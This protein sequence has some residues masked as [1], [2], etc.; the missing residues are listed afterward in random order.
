MVKTY[1]IHKITGIAAG[2]VLLLLAMSGF[3]LDHKQWDFLY[4]TTFTNVPQNVKKSDNRLFDSYW[5]DQ[6]DSNHAII[7]SKRGIY[8]TFDDG[9]SFHMMSPLQTQS[10][11]EINGQFYAATSDGVYL[12]QNSQWKSFALKDLYITSLAVNDDF[13]VAVVDKHE[14]VKIKRENRWLLSRNTVDIDASQLQESINLSRFVRDIHYARGLFEGDVSILINDY[15]TLFLG[16]LALSGYALWWLIRRKKTPKLTRKLIKTHSNSF[17]MIALFP[18]VLLAV[19]G[20]FLDHSNALMKFMTS[21]KIPHSVLPPV[22]STLHHDIWSVDF[23]GRIYRIGNRYGVYKSSDLKE[24]KLENRGF[25]YKMIRK[26][27]VLYVSGMGAPNRKYDGKW[28]ILKNTP[29]MF[30]DVVNKNGQIHY[31][32]FFKPTLPLP[33]FDDATLYSLILALHDGSFFASWWI[34]VDDLAALAIIL[35]GITG[36]IRWLKKRVKR[37]VHRT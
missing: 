9:N 36:T 26:G 22:Y 31:F 15:G 32:A 23:D 20:I 18:L 21:V 19:T 37:T 25:A 33:S 28:S 34:W 13:I 12:L 16:Y 2:A 30:R 4:S 8:E 24:W 11:K 7:G 10:I 1:K 29:H 27:N 6:K 3:L 35:L 14:I 17:A 5:V